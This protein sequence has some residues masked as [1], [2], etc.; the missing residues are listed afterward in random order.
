MSEIL[1]LPTTPPRE[2]NSIEDPRI[3]QSRRRDP[4]N[5]DPPRLMFNYASTI[6]QSAHNA[7]LRKFVA[8]IVA[9]KIAADLAL[10]QLIMVEGQDT[11]VAIKQGIETRFG[12][13][14][15]E[16]RKGQDIGLE[17]QKKKAKKS[18]DARRKKRRITVSLNSDS[19]QILAEV[20]WFYFTGRSPTS[21]A[22]T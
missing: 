2:F 10:S 11:S 15:L 13:L 19:V 9:G 18:R 14:R 6:L 4:N 8:E 3:L 5:D 12:S 22:N 20:D 1:E 7:D 21:A 16:W 17:T